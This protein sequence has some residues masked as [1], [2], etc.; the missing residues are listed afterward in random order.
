MQLLCGSTLT[1]RLSTESTNIQ[2]ISNET[3]M[4]FKKRENRQGEQH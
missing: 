4:C 2:L 3:L 1:Q